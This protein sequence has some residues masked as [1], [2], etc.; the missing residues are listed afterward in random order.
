M[1]GSLLVKDTFSAV[2]AQVRALAGAE[3][4]AQDS[5]T[6]ALHSSDSGLARFR[7]EAVITVNSAQLVAPLA[8][9]LWKNGVPLTQRGC[10]SS[11]TGGCAPAKGGAVLQLC[12]LDKILEIDTVSGYALV[13]AG[14]L[15]SVLQDALAKAGYFYAPLPLSSRSSTVG[16]NV[17]VNAAGP[18]SLKYGC[19]ADNLLEADIVT[20]EGAQL[21]LSRLTHGPDL[22]GFFSGMEG[23]F[24]TAVRLKVKIF[25]RASALSWFIAAFNTHEELLKAAAHAQL[26]G[27]HFRSLEA[28]DRMTATA[29]ESCFRLGY[30]LSCEALAVGELDGDAGAVEAEL[31][32]LRH[33][34]RTGGCVHFHSEAREPAEE[35]AWL[36]RRQAFAAVSRLAP[37]IALEDFSVPRKKLGLALAAAGAA[38]AQHDLRAGLVYSP[39]TGSVCPHI[40]FDERNVFETRRARKS[41][42]EMLKSCAELGGAVSGRFGIGVEK[43]MALSLQYS[44]CELGLLRALKEAADPRDLCNPEKIIPVATARSRKTTEQVLTPAAQ[45]LVAE[46]QKRAQRSGHSFIA[47]RATRSAGLSRPQAA[48][49]KLSTAALSSIVELDRDN[50]YIVAEAGISLADLA[51]QFESLKLAVPFSSRSGTLGGL[52]ASGQWLAPEACLVCLS[53]ALADGSVAQFG[54]RSLAPGGSNVLRSF[55][56]SWGSYGVLL[57]ATLSL[58]GAPCSIVPEQEEPVYKPLSGEVE[59]GIK[60]VFDPLGLLNPGL[61]AEEI[62]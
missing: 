22:P 46:L 23:T 4:V 55:L 61:T 42:L 62:S 34:C 49:E 10:G 25:K 43:R 15:N 47:G 52:L 39:C 60:K 27:V 20:P 57:T 38:L 11:L 21:R 50:G 45:A 12:R 18:R 7:P 41:A 58:C 17:S 44:D 24:G 9:L 59:L 16:G 26:Q 32:I 36:S 3:N 56:G 14:V 54:S 51:A 5:A 31:K 13:E 53:V 28:F 6:L 30:P 29:M 40:L 37:S 1:S 35:P 2:G 48:G 8:Q 19:A 33:V